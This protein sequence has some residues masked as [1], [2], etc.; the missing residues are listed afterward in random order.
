MKK[1]ITFPFLALTLI[2]VLSGC[3][4]MTSIFGSEEAAITAFTEA[5]IIGEPEIDAENATITLTVEP[6]DLSSFDPEI[7]ISESATL[8]EPESLTDGV[9]ATYTVTAENGDIVEWAVTVNVQYGI[10]FT[11][12]GTKTILLHGFSDSSDTTQNTSVG[13]GVP[14]IDK[15]TTESIGFAAYEEYD[16]GTTTGEPVYDYVMLQIEGITADTYTDN[17]F[18]FHDHS[19]STTTDFVV[20]YNVTEFGDVDETFRTTFSGEDSDG[21]EVTGGFAKLLVVE[22]YSF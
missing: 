9:A 16:W 6:M 3:D 13:D 15:T 4:L 19:E 18:R 12:G 14:G 2:L 21:T 10:S 17:S 11:I 5:G 1:H 8:V 22:Q 20:T 7:T